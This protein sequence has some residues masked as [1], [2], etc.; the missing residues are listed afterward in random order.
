MNNGIPLDY[1]ELR[2]ISPQAARQAILQILKANHGK[3][4]ITARQLGI[5]RKTVYKAITKQKQGSLKDTSRA[6]R[7]IPH[8]TTQ[9]LETQVVKLKQKTHYG[10]LR[11]AEELWETHKIKLSHHTIRNIIRR[12]KLKSQ[13][14]SHHPKKKG[15]RPFVDWYSAHAFEIVQ[16]DLKYVVD[17]KALTQEQINHIHYLHLPLY[18]WSALD[19]TSRFKLIAYSKEKTWTNGLT[20]FLWVTSWL[21]SHGITAQIIYTVDRGEE[22]GGKSWF[23]LV[24]LRKLLAAFGCKL[25][26]NHPHSPQENAHLERSHR[27]DDDEFYIPRVLTI[28]DQEAWFKEAFHYLYYY[29]VVRKHSSLG[30]KT[31]WQKL[32]E[33]LPHV[34]AKMKLVPPLL[35]DSLAV[36]LGSWSGYHVL[37]QHRVV[38]IDSITFC[39]YN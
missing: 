20:W 36:K 17:Q 31:P 22:F 2:S 18:Q 16:I 24:E 14:K 34:D 32:Q 37:A 25:I 10:P 1:Q 30:R 4:A 3:V 33:D 27:T 7:H 26:Q 39:Q 9:E 23:K 11:L 13:G 8:K 28:S 38:F 35:L 6:P 21:R 12:N 19:V 5:T 15:E 29:N